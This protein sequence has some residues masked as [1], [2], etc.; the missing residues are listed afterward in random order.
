[1]L[2]VF[3]MMMLN[4][5]AQVQSLEQQ[6]KNITEYQFY[7]IGINRTNIFID[8]EGNTIIPGKLTVDT[9]HVKKLIETGNSVWIGN[10]WIYTD[11][12]WQTKPA[13]LEIQCYNNTASPLGYPYLSAADAFRNVII[14]ADVTDAI[15]YPFITSNKGNVGIGTYS[16]QNKL[17]I[18]PNG[19]SPV[20][21]GLRLSGLTSPGLVANTGTGVLSVDPTTGDVIYVPSG[22]AANGYGFAA[23]SP[24]GNVLPNINPTGYGIELNNNNVY[25][26]DG[27]TLETT[28]TVNSLG[29]GWNCGQSLN[30]KVDI[31]RGN[32]ATSALGPQTNPIGLLIQ[33]Q[34]NAAGA[35][36][37]SIGME[38]GVSGANY[39]N[40]AGWF[41]ANNAVGAFSI[42]TGVESFATSVPGS[43][44]FYN[45]GGF[46]N[47]QD[48][49]W[50]LGV[51]GTA[52][53]TIG[54]YAT[55]LAN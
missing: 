23:C 21:S 15:H 14:S 20:P 5:K 19:N 40:Y 46:F 41:N 9:L 32:T 27:A 51:V 3:T 18:W 36:S 31:L 49:I 42:N 10:N 50:N 13:P 53:S 48:A 29:I 55:T 24:L 35:L 17:E 30:A 28:A 11:Q 16:P 52:N 44:S 33:N 8:N 1:M 54:G 37:S 45:E 47:A 43:P 39:Y 6:S 7:K 25:F 12:I 4:L 38:S 34:E 26:S 22:S 2:S